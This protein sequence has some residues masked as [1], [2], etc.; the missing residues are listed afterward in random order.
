MVGQRWDV[1]LKE[2]VNFND[3]EWDTKLQAYARKSGKLHPKSG[4]DYFVFPR[5]LYKDT[6]SFTIGRRCWDNWLMYQA[7]LLGASLIDATEVITAIHPNH[8][9]SHITSDNQSVWK[10]KE[11]IRNLELMEGEEH[12]FTIEHANWVLGSGGMKRALTIRSLYFQLVA[13]IIITPYLHFLSRLMRALTKLIIAIRHQLR[14][15][16]AS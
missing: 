13:S 1:D 8:D 11:H 6:P 16:T 3:P 2:L 4:S 7:R 10:G 14:G 12:A 15:I 5:G 9:Y